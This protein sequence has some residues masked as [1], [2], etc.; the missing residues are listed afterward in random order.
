MEINGL[1]L[2][3]ELYTV[4]DPAPRLS[5]VRACRGMHC[6]PGPRHLTRYVARATL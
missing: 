2:M 6:P 3:S 1:I 4:A 5:V